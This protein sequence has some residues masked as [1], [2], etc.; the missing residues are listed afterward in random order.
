M[1][2]PV[3]QSIGAAAV[4]AGETD[5]GI[6]RQSGIDDKTL[7]ALNHAPLDRPSIPV[8]HAPNLQSG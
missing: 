6:S 3:T 8:R 1:T 2:A 5:W 7:T 4:A